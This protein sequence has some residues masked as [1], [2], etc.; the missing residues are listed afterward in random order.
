MNRTMYGGMIRT[1]IGWINDKQNYKWLDGWDD[2]WMGR[3]MDGWKSFTVGQMD[4]QMN[5]MMDG[6]AE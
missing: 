1:M 2:G 6:L 3:V 4:G 5:G